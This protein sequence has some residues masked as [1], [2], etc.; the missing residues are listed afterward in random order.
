MTGRQKRYLPFLIGT[1]IAAAALGGWLIWRFY[2][3]IQSLM[4]PQN[5]AAFQERLSA[6]GIW[7]ILVLFSMQTL[8]VISGITPALPIQICAGITYG[9]LGGLLLCMAGNFCR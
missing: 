8:Q 2:P 6:F 7:G 3:A 9:A 5:M 4:Q 1:A